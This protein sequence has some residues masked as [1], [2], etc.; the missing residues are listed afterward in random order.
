MQVYTIHALVSGFLIHCA[1][2]LLPNKT[3]E[4]YD[5]MRNAIRA[6]LGDEVSDAGR[7][8]TIDFEQASINADSATFPWMA[9]A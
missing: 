9:L 4:T 3:T 2:D 5:T 8:L 7:L 6:Q 1:C